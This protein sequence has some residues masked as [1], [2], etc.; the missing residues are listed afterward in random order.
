MLRLDPTA[1]EWLRAARGRAVDAP[2]A[3]RALLADRSRVEVGADEAERALE[4][5]ARLPGWRE[6]GRPPLF[7]YA[8][9]EILATP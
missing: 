7:A 6:D 1:H 9:G 2:D 4:W 8:P 3:I 5:A